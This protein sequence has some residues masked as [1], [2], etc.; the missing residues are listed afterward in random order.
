MALKL[1][2]EIYPSI[3]S[4]LGWEKIG[5]FRTLNQLA[6]ISGHNRCVTAKLAV[7][8]LLLKKRKVR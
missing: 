6:A 8:A 3:I 7:V 1:V 2:G 5:L 4:Q